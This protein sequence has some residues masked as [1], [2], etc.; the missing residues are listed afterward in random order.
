MKTKLLFLIAFIGLSF[1]TVF[2]QQATL[3]VSYP[4]GTCP[5]AL[6]QFDITPASIGATFNWSYSDGAT[7]TTTT[8][9]TTHTFTNGGYQ[10]ASV[11][12]YDANG[13]YITNLW[14]QVN[15]AGATSINFNPYDK[16]VCPGDNINMY[17]SYYGNGATFTWSFG[18]GSSPQTGNNNGVD[19]TY[20]TAGNY[21]VTCTAQF[22]GCPNS[23]LTDTV[24]VISNLPINTGSG[25]GGNGLYF[26]HYPDSACIGDAVSANFSSYIYSH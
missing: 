10:S 18:D 7:Q 20:A 19:H 21:T 1:T 2:A 16:K 4:S 15:L 3:T 5:P 26:G 12:I 8:A 13:N 25:A 22:P 24:H 6:V 11:Y 9:S 17:V 23:V 14:G